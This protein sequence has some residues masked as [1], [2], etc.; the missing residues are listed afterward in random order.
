MRVLW[1]CNTVPPECCEI[2]GFRKRYYE[3][4]ITG[5]LDQVKRF[6]DIYLG[7][8]LPIRNPDRMMDGKTEEYQYY[9]FHMV[10][11]YEVSEEMINRFYCILDDFKP[12]VI[13]IWGSEYGQ[14]LAMIRASKRLGISDKTIVHIQGLISAMPSYYAVRIPYKWITHDGENEDSIK[15]ERRVFNDRGVNEKAILTEVGC[16]LGRTEWDK[17]YI[18]SVS[19][20]QYKYCGEILR[21][22]FY[23][24]KVNWKY[25]NCIKHSIFITQGGY[26]LKGIHLIIPA[27]AILKKEY[28]DISVCISGYSTL[29]P[30]Y[31]GVLDPYGEYLLSLLDE[32]DVKDAFHFIGSLNPDEMVERYLKSNILAVPSALENSSNSIGEAQLLGVPVV[33]TYT[34]GTPS[35]IEHGR[36]GL[37]YQMDAPYMFASCVEKIFD[38]EEYAE[39]LSENEREVAK[40]RYDPETVGN[41]LYEIYKEVAGE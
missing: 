9:S 34:G 1:L 28:P 16:A 24:E 14:S 35:L 25:D 11:M 38:D 10:N 30:D 3:S 23:K 32:Y 17:G 29:V 27:I 15:N 19:Q 4:W 8:C 21:D 40:K 41:Q 37:M 18:K 22:V 36:T 20:I 33:A 12:D 13:H 7:I 6:D 39:Y 2:F 26:A 5:T 31:T